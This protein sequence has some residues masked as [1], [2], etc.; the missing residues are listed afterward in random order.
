[1]QVVLDRSGSMDGE[2]LDAAKQALG[3]LVDRL[4]PTDRFGVV[5][6]DDEVQVVVPAGALHDK[7]ARASARSPPST[8]A[9]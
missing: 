3:A 4:D 6:F 5:A 7:A 8:P 1:M 2:R 9:A